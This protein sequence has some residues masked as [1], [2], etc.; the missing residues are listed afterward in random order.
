MGVLRFSTDMCTESTEI[1]LVYNLYIPL[2]V[3]GLIEANFNEF[4]FTI[5]W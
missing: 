2:W 5:Y 1:A 3:F 4:A